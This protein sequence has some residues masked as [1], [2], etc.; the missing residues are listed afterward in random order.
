MVLTFIVK[1]GGSCVSKSHRVLVFGRWWPP[2]RTCAVRCRCTSPQKLALKEQTP[3]Q[4]R[5][6][7]GDTLTRLEY[8]WLGVKYQRQG[9]VPTCR[10]TLICGRVPLLCD[11]AGLFSGDQHSTAENAVASTS[12]FETGWSKLG[13]RPV[14]FGFLAM[15]E[16]FLG[17][18]G[19]WFVAMPI[20]CHCT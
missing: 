2:C 12:S 11:R 4:L 16:T 8:E 17:I 5:F 7:A 3:G 19:I 9:G 18:D 15:I 1:Y 14:I 10:T 20:G 13:S 6:V